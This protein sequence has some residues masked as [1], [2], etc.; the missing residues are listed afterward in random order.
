MQVYALNYLNVEL[1]ITNASTLQ[2]SI[3]MIEDPELRQLAAVLVLKTIDAPKYFCTGTFDIMK[4][5][6]FAS[7]VPLFTHFTAP[8]R[9]YADV[10]VHRQLEATLQNG[11][12][13]F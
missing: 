5:A 2:H 3:E 6:H 13:L 4:Y 8:L 11:I 9:R 10:I 7:G 12:V 1:D